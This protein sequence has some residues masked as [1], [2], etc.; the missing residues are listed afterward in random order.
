[1]AKAALESVP[2]FLV[3]P[4][5]LF[6]SFSLVV[7]VG[8]YLRLRAVFYLFL[9]NALL[10]VGSGIAGTGI[11]LRLP[12]E[13]AVLNQRTGALCGGGVVLLGV[14]MFLLLLQIE[15]DFFFAEKR[16]LL[17]PDRDATNG[18]ALLSSGRHYAKSKKWAMAVIHLR[19]A[20]AQMPHQVDPHLALSVAYLNLKR[21]KLAAGALEEARRIDPDHSQ[22]EHLTN[23]LMSQRAA[24]YPARSHT[25]E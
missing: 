1:M 22:I 24:K 19:R 9:V 2:R 4:P 20:A 16:L 23:V 18:P 7:L 8:L 25:T 10:M 12:S 3:L 15:D 6:I 11:G 14:L 13:A 21:D 5:L 17:R